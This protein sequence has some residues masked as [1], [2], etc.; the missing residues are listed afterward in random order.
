VWSR[1]VPLGEVRP[2]GE[3]AFLIGVQDATAAR[4]LTRALAASGRTEVSR[5]DVVAGLATVMVSWGEAGAE[6][7]QDSDGF[8][9]WLEGMVEDL[10][11]TIDGA[12]EGAVEEGALV[13]VPCVFDGPD[14]VE[15]AGLAGCEPDRVVELVT[16]QPLTVGVIGFSPGFAYLE[17]LPDELS[18]I[19]RRQRPRPMVPAGSVALA[20]GHAAVYPSA[21]PGGWQLIGRTAETFFSARTPPYARLAPGDRVQFVARSEVAEPALRSTPVEGRR[22]VGPDT[23]FVVERAGVHTRLQDGGRSGVAAIGV[24]GAGPADP[25]SFV[26]AN[27]L[28]GNPPDA[29]ELEVTAQGPA[30]RCVRPAYV[31]VVGGRPE[32]FLDGRPV[33]PGRV[34]PVAA[35]Q[36][37][38][39]GPVRH[40]LR[41][42]LAVAG[43]FIG[44]ELFGSCAA[45][46]LS[47]LGPSPVAAGDHLG[48]GDLHPPLG[49]H[50]SG[51]VVADL[52]SGNP[53]ALRVVPGPHR[54]RFAPD[55]FVSLAGR[56]FTV[57]A[58]SN[59][60]GLRLEPAVGDW[61]T[62]VS[63]IDSHGVVTGAVQVP[64][65]GHPVILL[66]DHATLGG[67]PV[68]AVV[69]AVD[70][71][72]L[73]QCAPGVAVALVPVEPAEARR[74]WVAQRRTLGSALIGAYPLAID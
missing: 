19:P 43:G 49:D 48:A 26:L 4:A 18:R 14:L 32:V 42:Y 11:G 33:P 67:Y 2:L 55:A 47:G 38:D 17:G 66:P 52:E 15:V 29:G 30:L 34:V 25:V 22:A 9:R 60:I 23:V 13:T 51:D 41:C 63:E 24:P 35:G 16:A 6:P 36:R 53:V 68:L 40:G 57:G 62:D 39:V 44:P 58:Q 45:D 10:I 21:S 54:E 73:G 8:R 27:R 31:A 72:R 1:S 69:A 64:P 20:N 5:C 74:A 56:R 7:D 46:Q 61:T 50:L 71:G 65:D 3:R 70:H 59:R 12:F 37:L 28:V